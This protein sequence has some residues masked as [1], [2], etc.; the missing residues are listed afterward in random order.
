VVIRGGD[1]GRAGAAP[2]R[3]Q[4]VR[5]LDIA[6]WPSSPPEIVRRIPGWRD[7]RRVRGDRATRCVARGGHLVAD[8]GRGVKL[9][10][11]SVSSSTHTYQ[12]GT[13]IYSGDSGWHWPL[14]GTD[15]EFS[16]SFEHL[17]GDTTGVAEARWPRTAR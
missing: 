14:A 10:R 4:T 11:F 17:E 1:R 2:D 6:A 3:N 16:S 9:E 8:F 5:T 12:A 7:R 15:Q 13:T